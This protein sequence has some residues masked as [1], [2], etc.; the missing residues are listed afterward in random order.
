VKLRWR[1]VLSIGAALAL[2]EGVLGLAYYAELQRFLLDHSAQS[3][4]AQAKP[5]VDRYMRQLEATGQPLATVARPLAR[6][7]TS[8]ETGALVLDRSG[9]PLA[10][11]KFLPEEPAPVVP[12]PALVERAL[13]GANELYRVLQDPTGPQLVAYVPLRVPV[14]SSNIV[15]VAQLN[16]GLGEAESTLAR[17]RWLLGLTF[18]A[19]LGAGA[20]LA[21][22]LGHHIALPLE[23]LADTC[24]AIAAGSWGRRSELPHGRDEVGQ[25]ARSFDEMVQRLEQLIAA[26]QRFAADAGHQLKTPLAALRGHVELLRRGLIGEPDRVRASYETMQELV[27]RMSRM[28]RKLTTLSN[29]DAGV[30][31]QRADTDL[32]AVARAVLRDFGPAASGLRL[33]VVARD[34]ARALVDPAQLYEA[35]GNLVDN[36]IRHTPPGG[37][38]TVEV[39][40]GRVRVRDTGPGIPPDRLTRIFDRFYRYPPT[41]DG[42]GLG[43]AIVQSIVRANGGTVHVA[44]EP[45][46]GAVFTLE[47]P[48]PQ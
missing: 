31:A 19:T 14:G 37:A 43:L 4:R 3:L 47:F 28:V 17:V 6:D 44:S 38:I 16:R 34:G 8:R 46:R 39:E 12:D 42:A 15:G 25:L 33:E 9:R 2:I 18:A 23:R 29:L 48:T 27:D 1:I 5:V 36:A 40:P 41:G 45:G 30:P 35:L 10:F 24:R 11:G 20:V 13:A 7:L 32:V 22:L 21:L 26:Q